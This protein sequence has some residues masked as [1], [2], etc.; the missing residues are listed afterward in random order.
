[1]ASRNKSALVIT[2]SILKSDKGLS[3]CAERCSPANVVQFR[4][5]SFFYAL[6][7]LAHDTIACAQPL[8]APIFSVSRVF[9]IGKKLFYAIASAGNITGLSMYSTYRERVGDSERIYSLIMLDPLYFRLR[10]N[11]LR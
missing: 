10:C 4:Q 11:F 9:L 3:R 6:E 8:F 2:R 7:V 5:V 1:M